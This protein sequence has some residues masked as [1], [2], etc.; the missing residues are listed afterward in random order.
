[1][2]LP[3]PLKISLLLAG[4][5][6]ALYAALLAT[7]F[8]RYGRDFNEQFLNLHAIPFTAIFPFWLVVFYIAGLYDLP[9]LR[10][11]LEFLQ[12]LAL[13]LFVNALL[14]IAAFYLVPSFGITP[15]TN[16]FLF[17]IVFAV[18]ES[19]WRRTW[20]MRASFREGLNR[21]LLLDEG[22]LAKEL[23][24]ILR[25]NPQVGYA[26]K[27]HMDAA[28]APEH[29]DALIGDH[30][31]TLV[32]VPAR[33]RHDPASAR[34]LY[35]LLASG[36]DVQDVPTF[37]EAVFRKVPLN[38][39]DE[40]WFIERGIGARRFYDDLKRGLEIAA[41][42]L[43]GIVLLPLEL[44]IAILIKLTSHGP[45]LYRQLRLGKNGMPFLLYKFRSMRALS[46]DGS[47]ETNG[48]VWSGAHDDRT[49]AVGRVLRASHLD[50]LPQLWNVIHGELSFVGPRPERP[51]IVK[52]L[53]AEVP[54]Y[55][56]RLIVK[57][58][59][60]G[61]AQI[62]HRKDATTAD[63]MEKLAYDVYY[64]KNRSLILDIAIIVK[65]IKSFFVNHE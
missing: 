19:W 45:V 65:T 56:I 14:T 32:V 62:N 25:E 10:N 3:N 13:T 35:E 55:E 4:D 18:L 63:V 44:L 38:A 59:I 17:L 53:V 64:L 7:L 54:Y 50:E 27:A 6:V 49:T 31:I 46:A 60:T 5:V 26:V 23:Q 20:N 34:V 41:A 36:I 57:P 52:R 58:G 40:S 2:R 30:R 28:H 51:E 1:M 61:W 39:I 47:A 15:K 24:H 12:T 29:L 9:R 21:V 22:P 37:Y 33:M 42:V 11:N 48:A 8:I 43:L 16:L